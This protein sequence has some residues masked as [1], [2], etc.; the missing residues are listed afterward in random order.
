MAGGPHGR[1][2]AGD[3]IGVLGSRVGAAGEGPGALGPAAAPFGSVRRV[4]DA[5]DRTTG[6]EILDLSAGR[7]FAGGFPHD[8]FA[9][10]LARFGSF[11]RAGSPSWPNNNRLVGMTRLPVIVGAEQGGAT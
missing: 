2:D 11:E 6:T 8:F 10:L 4:T 9:W 3:A 5:R 1:A 7:T